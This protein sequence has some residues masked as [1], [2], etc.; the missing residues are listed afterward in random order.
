MSCEPIE[1]ARAGRPSEALELIC[2]AL[3][4]GDLEAAVALYEPRA[5][6]ALAGETSARQADEV[7]EALAEL[8]DARLPVKATVT[9]ELVS[10]DLALV[11]V[12]REMSGTGSDGSPLAL[13]GEGGSLLRRH[14][15]RGWR[16]VVDDWNL[17]SQL[18][19]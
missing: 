1:P 8:M 3:S 9:R 17:T 11:L 14:D 13:K 10:G 2:Q 15:D 6:L 4:D 18:G 12:V 16:L 7:R 19:R 5:T